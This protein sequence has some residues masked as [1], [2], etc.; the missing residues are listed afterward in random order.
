M[1]SV[2]AQKGKIIVKEIP[3]PACPENG[4]L[5]ETA[6]SLISAGTEKRNVSGSKMSLASNV[7]KN[8]ISWV[9][10]QVLSKGGVFT[11]RSVGSYLD[12]ATL[13]GYSCAGKVIQT[14]KSITDL[15]V[16]DFVSCAGAGFATHSDFVAV[17]RN[18]VAKIPEGVALEE[19]AFSTVGSI[20][21][22]AI[23]QAELK[24]G[25]QVVVIGLGLVGMMCMTLLRAFGFDAVGIDLSAEKVGFA[26]KL[27]FKAH[28]SGDSVKNAHELAA[29]ADAV[30]IAAASTN[31]QPLKLAGELCR[32][33]GTI[34]IIGVIKIEIDWAVAY[35]KEIKI[36]MARSYG[37]GRYDSTYEIDGIDYPIDYVRF[38]ERRNMEL[39][40][41]LISEKKI[42]LKPFI[43]KIFAVAEADKAY[44]FLREKETIGVLLQYSAHELNK[45]MRLCERSIAR[46]SAIKTAVIG[47]GHFAKEVHF[48]NLFNNKNFHIKYVVSATGSSA[49][50]AAKLIG[51]E[52]A[53]TDFSEVLRDPEIDLVFISTP[54]EMHAQMVIAALNAGKNVFVEKPLCVNEEELK[55]IENAFNKKSLTLMVGH[56][57]RYSPLSKKLK[58]WMDCKRRPAFI[59]YAVAIAPP[60]VQG[61][62]RWDGGR[63]IEEMTHFL[64][65]FRFLAGSEPIKITAHGLGGLSG[66][67]STN[68]NIIVN[69]KFKDGSLASLQ[70][71]TIAA[72][73]MPKE[74]LVVHIDGATASITDFK[75][76]HL[77]DSAQNSDLAR[78]FPEKGW[79]EELAVL[80]DALHGK[81]NIINDLNSALWS[82]RAAFD[83][84]KQIRTQATENI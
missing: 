12:R 77:S 32:S 67:H 50:A 66:Q 34:V 38:T 76:M 13:L 14:G 5:V 57:R 45:S 17:P 1:K 29:G 8:K 31:S 56:N 42:S 84:V 3:A 82:Q 43:S 21:M 80:A 53:A 16:G 39:F 37:P 2:V 28:L 41:S 69:V 81:K 10:D 52:I 30:F 75:E 47:P 70:F 7:S 44:D 78:K 58:E 25:E 18:L 26:K 19:A 55:N 68:N 59:T 46:S 49:V 65:L 51:A 36:L 27:G 23:H 33:R 11:A 22:H 15:A 40:L 20:A 60:V 4:V 71:T 74:Q 63:I 83:I 72:H 64:D 35:R 62:P 6:Y 73:S 48:P 54:P 9:K 24:L 61:L 79:R